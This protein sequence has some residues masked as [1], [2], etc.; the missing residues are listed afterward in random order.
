MPPMLQDCIA[1]MPPCPATEIPQ[2]KIARRA[3]A[4]GLIAL[5]PYLAVAGSFRCDYPRSGFP[6]HILT[7]DAFLHGQLHLRNDILQQHFEQSDQ[8]ARQAAEQEQRRLGETWPAEVVEEYVRIVKME[9][10]DL[11]IIGDRYYTYWG[12]LASVVMMPFVAMFGPNVSDR[13]MTALFGGLNVALAYWM[14][15]NIDRSG[16]RRLSESCCIGL[17][18]LLGLGTVHFYLSCGGMVWFSVQIIT[19]TALLLSIIA[20]TAQRNSPGIY[21]LCGAMF[22]AAVLGRNIVLLLG[23]FYPIVIWIRQGG[24]DNRFRRCA[25]R[26]IAF[27]IPV[28]LSGL[29]QLAYN[30]G[31][32]GNAFETGEGITVHTGGGSLFV[33]DYDE[34]GSFNLHYL[35]NNLYYYFWNHRF[36][37]PSRP[38]PFDPEGNS[39]FLITPPLLYLLLLWRKRDGFTLALLAGAIPVMT[40]LL[41]FRATGYFQFGNRYL[42]DA[43]PLL[44]LLVAGGMAGRLTLPGVLLIAIAV[45]MNC[46][47]TLCYLPDQTGRFAEGRTPDFIA[48][49]AMLVT[50][51][52]GLLW[53]RRTPQPETD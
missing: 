1:D 15:R 6:H 43:M 53:L 26:V 48:I 11:A 42:L 33:T 46:F 32:F 36:R 13:L 19:T 28:V 4:L 30:Y 45:G 3:S 44:L 31:R 35:P 12:P 52:A 29:I 16:L 40:A 49:T 9:K 5:I 21:A 50:A 27:G 38:T 10:H 7:A 41:L 39:M 2:P 18:L 22:G 20:L 47:G 51:L 34:Y 25:I 8:R 24:L 23:L 17:T 14:F 37:A